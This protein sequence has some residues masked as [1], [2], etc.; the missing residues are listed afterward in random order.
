MAKI[1]RKHPN[2]IEAPFPRRL[3][4]FL[5]DFIVIVIIGILAYMSIDAIYYQTSAGQRSRRQSFQ[6]SSSLWTILD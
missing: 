1:V 6:C 2:I 5:I 3:G 4:A